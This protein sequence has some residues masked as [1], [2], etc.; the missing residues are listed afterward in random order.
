MII[1][2][3]RLWKRNCKIGQLPG[4]ISIQAKIA[5]LGLKP[6]LLRSPYR[7]LYT[8]KICKEFRKEHFKKA[9]RRWRHDFTLAGL[10]TVDE[11][12]DDS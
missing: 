11:E 4:D 1:S 7:E 8:L 3:R 9:N 5:I 12:L 6:H 10:H 2:D